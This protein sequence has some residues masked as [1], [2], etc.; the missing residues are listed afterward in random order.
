[1]GAVLRFRLQIELHSLQILPQTFVFHQNKVITSIREPSRTSQAEQ[2]LSGS[3]ASRE[4]GLLGSFGS[5]MMLGSL[6]TLHR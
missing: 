3:F 2:V 6:P 4:N 1:V 5:F